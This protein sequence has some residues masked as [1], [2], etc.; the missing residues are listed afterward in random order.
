MTDPQTALP[1]S[2][3]TWK[4]FNVRSLPRVT[5]TMA[6]ALVPQDSGAMTARNHYVARWRRERTEH[7]E[8][9]E[10]ACVKR[11]GKASTAMCAEPTTLAML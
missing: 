9:M 2:T 1:A 3:A 4:S 6:N 5:N 11:A 10:T 8:E 7:R